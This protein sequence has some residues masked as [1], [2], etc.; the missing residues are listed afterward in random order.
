MIVERSMD[1]GW[2]SNSYLVADR[3]D[4][5][6]VLIDAGGPPEPLEVSVERYRLEVTHLLLTHHHG[7]H[8]AHV[9]RAR[10]GCWT[11]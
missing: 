7:D 4:G 3:P 8:V 1:P 5:S 10:A 11:S 2:L 9:D 6:A